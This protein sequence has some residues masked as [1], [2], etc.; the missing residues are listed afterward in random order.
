MLVS[1][2]RQLYTKMTTLCNTRDVIMPYQPYTATNRRQL[3]APK[4]HV[5][6]LLIRIQDQDPVYPQSYTTSGSAPSISISKPC[7]APSAMPLAFLARVVLQAPLLFQSRSFVVP[8]SHRLILQ[9]VYSS[10]ILL[11]RYSF[12]QGERKG[13]SL[14]RVLCRNR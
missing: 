12:L 10:C 3:Q 11:R 14:Q 6:S 8:G 1:S 7:L 2:I 13:M 4:P 9:R 5:T